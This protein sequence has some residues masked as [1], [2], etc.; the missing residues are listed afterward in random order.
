MNV[1]HL[2]NI[3]IAAAI[4]TSTYALAACMIP[5]Y[6]T[7]L[8]ICEVAGEKNVVAIRVVSCND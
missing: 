4:T 2:L 8:N 5:I 3:P 6:D 7:K 1:I